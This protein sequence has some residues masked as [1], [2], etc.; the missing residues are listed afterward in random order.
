LIAEAAYPGLDQGHSLRRLD[1]LAA[2]VR[3]EI[4]LQRGAIL[5]ARMLGSRETAD[6]VCRALRDVLAGRAGFHGNQEE[7]Y[8]PRT[9][10]LNDVLESRTGL[11]ITLSIV[12]IEVARRLGAP[13]VGVA[14]PG[15]FITKWPLSPDEGDDFF[16]DPFNGTPLDL[17]ECRELAQRLI[18]SAG[19]PP[20]IDP[21]WLEPAPTRAV[22]TRVLY[23]VKHAY[24]QRGETAA[25]LDMV[26]RLIILRP[27]LPEE[28]RDRGLLRL[29][30]GEVL[31]AAADI[32][33][34]ARR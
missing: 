4:G 12:Y 24:L 6:R 22:L 26:E 29:A 33:A 19:G 32:T 7:Y 20:H 30:L 13:L 25:A 28:L 2:T 14:L 3:P 8:P 23:N 21:A 34:Y 27:D 17:D 11:P 15:H 31:L 10:F 18:A 1:A 5:P 9:S 16:V